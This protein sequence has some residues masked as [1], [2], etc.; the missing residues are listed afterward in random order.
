[1]SVTVTVSPQKLSW[2]D[3]LSVQSLP[4]SSGDEAQTATTMPA[5]SGIHPVLVH[6][7]FTL[8]DVT[9]SVGLDRSQ[10]MVISTAQKTADLLK[11]EQGHFDIT[12]LTVR[13]LAKE[14]E[15]LKAGSPAALGQQLNALLSKHQ[16]RANMIE[17]KYDKETDH[18]RDQDAQK[19]WNDAID[20]AMKG[21]GVSILRGMHL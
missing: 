1:M 7:K 13:A 12:V 17:E 10:T 14:M 15:Q 5:L 4:D 19:T 11:H 2:N 20:A 3:F 21:A 16:Q 6:G 18:S 9:L 8:P